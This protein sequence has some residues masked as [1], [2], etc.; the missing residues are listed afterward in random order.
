MRKNLHFQWLGVVILAVG[1]GLVAQAARGASPSAEAALKLAPIQKNVE[2]DQPDAQEAAKCQISSA[3]VGRHTGWVVE[4]PT[5]LIL[6]RFL[7][8]NGDNS[9]D[10]WSYYKDGLEVYRDIDADFDGKADQYRW[11]H[12]GG[13]RWGLDENEDGQIDQ[14]K[15]ISAEEVAA[16]TAAAI[17]QQD[18][19]RF[20]KL[21]LTQEELADLGLGADRAKEL[22][23]QIADA[24]KTFAQV[25]S[26]QNAI[27]REAKWIQFSGGLPGVVPSG[28]DGSTKDLQVYENVTSIVQDSGKHAEIILGTLVKAGDTW[29][30]VTAPRVVEEGASA[31][32]TGIFFQP[33][34]GARPKM[35]SN[36]PSPASQ[37]LIDELEQIDKLLQAATSK[38]E[39][40]KLNTQR[41]EKLEQIAQAA[42]SPEERSMWIRQ[43]A[44]MISAATQVGDFPDGPKALEQL[45][46]RLK[47]DKNDRE[48]AAYVR[49][50]EITAEYTQAFQD[51]KPDVQKIQARWVKSLKQ[52]IE[53]YPDTQE[54]PE[55]MLQLAITQE[56]A[57]E[58]EDAKKWYARTA[59]EFPSAPA[60][61]KAAG[62]VTRLESVGKPI[63]LRGTTPSGE[64]VDLGQ[65]RGKAVVIQYWQTTSDRA[66]TDMAALKELAAKHQ[67]DLRVIGVNLDYNLKDLT[68]FLK[69]HR[70]PWPQI[71][72]EGGLDSRPANEMGIL[73]VPTV[74]L[75]DQQGNVVRWNLEVAELDRELGKLLR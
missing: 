31:M 36:G 53:D 17:A 26:Q 50:R 20:A 51:P 60:A 48:L 62:A 63:R 37:K 68:N 34:G 11:F 29:R 47:Q 57:G 32:A 59:K 58:E 70:L 18:A 24:P 69:E 13:S 44:D 66:K 38:D 25:A 67:S 65:Y 72:E 5:G 9:L 45:Y 7:D 28:T 52:F 15:Q 30:V 33:A 19:E 2:Y 61:K 55:A 42:G 39:K 71:F 74:I 56:F 3:K 49:F 41:A 6:R 75:V 35:A 21:V 64:T 4:G 16:E 10:Q 27:G 8:T 14:W 73:T 43:M 46:E 54:T 1:I 40:A 22:A 23:R 12:T